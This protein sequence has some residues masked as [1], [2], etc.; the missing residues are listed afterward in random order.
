M[1]N[2]AKPMPILLIEDNETEVQCFKEYLKTRDD[3]NLVKSTN[4]SYQ[5]IEYTKMYIPEGIILDLELHKGEGSGISFLENLQ[6]LNLDFKPLIVV[7]T[8][9][10]SNIIYNHIRE[11]G[12]DFIFY[13]NQSDYCPEIVINSMISLRENIHSS[14]TDNRKPNSTTETPEEYEKRIRE[15]INIEL[16][17][18]G[19][20]NHLKGRRYIFDAIFYLID[21]KG[22]DDSSVFYYLS[23]LY[24]VGNSS[25]SR[26][27]QTAINYAWKISSIDDL[28]NYY[29]ARINYETGVPT[30]TEFIYYYAEKVRKLL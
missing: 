11:L 29:T 17:L 4:S 5:A 14:K 18:I 12:A 25:I 21:N 23:N 28:M 6:K 27:M 10:S 26:A 19:I 22:K 13:K 30:P 16:D 20:A 3:V 15:K 7:T 1:L 9:V 2:I 8:N 24:K